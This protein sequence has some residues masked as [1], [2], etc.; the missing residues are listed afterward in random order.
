MGGRFKT[1]IL[2]EC[3]LPSLNRKTWNRRKENH[4]TSTTVIPS[5]QLFTLEPYHIVRQACHPKTFFNHTLHGL[6]GILGA[7]VD[8]AKQAFD[9]GRCS[10]IAFEIDEGFAVSG[11]GNLGG[12]L[13][14]VRKVVAVERCEM[15]G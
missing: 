2:K 14:I 4:E 7:G 13:G 15:V 11:A 9:N 3:S 8:E 12:L 10:P 5:F 1:G 6:K